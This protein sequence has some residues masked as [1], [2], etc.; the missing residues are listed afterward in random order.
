[1]ALANQL[2]NQAKPISIGVILVFGKKKSL[3]AVVEDQVILITG[4]SSGIGLATAY[5]VA[6]AGAKTILVSRG[7]DALEKAKFELAR[8]GHKIYVYSAD[9]SD[10]E[11]LDDLVR[12][13]QDE[14]GVI[15]IL[16][17]N[18]G[19][20]IRRSVEASFDRFHDYERT[21]RLN[22][23]G[24]LRMTLSILPGMVEQGR[25]HVIN[26]SSIG[27]QINSPR[28]SAYVASK[29]AL[30]AFTRV[31]SAEFAKDSVR[32]TTVSMPLVRT[33]MI[34]PTEFSNSVPTI[35]PEQAAEIVA[36]AIIR[37]PKKIS[38]RLGWLGQA[39]YFLF[40]SAMEI[41]LSR[42]FR[43]SRDSDAARLDEVQNTRRRGN[44]SI[45][46]N[47]GSVEDLDDND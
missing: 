45:G 31:A 46:I 19:R 40:P 28:F 20:S 8:S 16:I 1:L 24:A 7:L 33:P 26:I 21:M 17:N 9:L 34:A 12:K 36:R 27:V 43:S 14:H 11:A 44:H 38:T 22:Y 10:T 23:F 39:V 42:S 25:G 37:Q 15:D 4:G 5:S 35:S 18:A 47:D 13:I 2:T 3:N 30:D 32:F 41:G 29:A 6:H